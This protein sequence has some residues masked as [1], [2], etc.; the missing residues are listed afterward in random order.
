MLRANLLK[1]FND[2]IK[3]KGLMDNWFERLGGICFTNCYTP[4]P[5]TARSSACLYSGKYPKN[6]GC[7]KRLQWPKYYLKLDIFSIFD[8]FE[9]YNYLMLFKIN[10]NK[11]KVG[12]LPAKKYKNMNIFN[13]LDECLDDLEE[14]IDKEE[15]IFSFIALDDYHWAMGDY[16]ANSSGDYY[17]QKH[18]SNCFGKI[19]NR[20][21]PDTFDYIFIFSDHGCKLKEELKTEKKIYLIN[22][23]RTKIVM[24]VRE[25]GCEGIK[26]I[27]SLTSIMDI[28][29]TLTRIMDDKT[30][31]SF[32]GLSLFEKLE[33]R[34]IVI[35]DYIG[36]PPEIGAT[37]ELWGI[38]TDTHFYLCRLS[39]DVLL[40]VISENGYSEEKNKD[41]SLI[42]EF[43][44]KIG[45]IA[46]S[47][48][49]NIRLY[50]ILK[51][52]RTL[53]EYRDKYSDGEKRMGK[54]DFLFILKKKILKNKYKRW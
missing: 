45:N 44:V 17:G 28:L 12:F 16:G 18:L 20:F 27:S 34:Y 40:K 39:E 41:S 37:H 3:E 25:K 6:N 24:Y 31:Y 42:A 47:Y 29:P 30:T 23:A 49:E 22:D 7:C 5:D 43:Q 9:K 36:F 35:E 33:N 32:D 38:R 51:N 2:N 48:Y 15:N 1:T 54:N 26:K 53:T 19:F 21:A 8:L 11:E 50:K 14:V 46:C 4:A 52:Y 13:D 10:K